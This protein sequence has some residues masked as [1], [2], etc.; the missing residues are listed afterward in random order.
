ME[1]DRETEKGGTE[2]RGRRRGEKE[3]VTVGG[4]LLREGQKQVREREEKEKTESSSVCYL[5]MTEG[6]ASSG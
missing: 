6:N 1:T 2:V 4:K 5:T 3:T